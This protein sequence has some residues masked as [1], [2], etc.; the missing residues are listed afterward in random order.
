[1]HGPMRIP[2]P[3]IAHGIVLIRPA[4]VQVLPRFP[5]FVILPE[6]E[7]RADQRALRQHDPEHHTGIASHRTLSRPVHAAPA[8]PRALYQRQAP[9]NQMYSCLIVV[10]S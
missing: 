5:T 9:A 6:M 2:L 4:S 7:P 1:M 10:I 3:L 8:R